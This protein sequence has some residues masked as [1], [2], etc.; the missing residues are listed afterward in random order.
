[1][2]NL[3]IPFISARKRRKKGVGFQNCV[4]VGLFCGDLVF[5]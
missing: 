4:L 2:S 1:M 3:K 5:V